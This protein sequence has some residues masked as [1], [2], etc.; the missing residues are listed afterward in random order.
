MEP[1][2][3][4]KQL[5]EEATRYEA[6]ARQQDHMAQWT[7]ST[8]PAKHTRKMIDVFRAAADLIERHE[9]L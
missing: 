5:R 8:A 3:I 4:A 6:V 2:D 7:A 1:R 9:Q